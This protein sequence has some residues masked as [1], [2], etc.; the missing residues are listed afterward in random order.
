MSKPRPRSSSLPPSRAVALAAFRASLRGGLDLQSAL[1]EAIRR[2]ALDWR[3]AGLATE[4]VYGTLRLKG[5]LDALCDRFLSDPGRVPAKLRDILEI[6]AYEILFLDKVPDYASVDWAVSAARSDC[7]QGLAGLC[8]AVL[9]KIAKLG[10]VAHDPKFYQEGAKDEAAFL[11]RWHSCPEWMVRLWR[12]Q[13]PPDRVQA[14][15]ESQCRPPALGMR[16]N[17]LYGGH[18][19]LKADLLARPGLMLSEGNCLAFS[20]GT[21]PA[22]EI[23]P[24]LASGALSRQSAASQLAVHCLEPAQWPGPIWDACA[25]R[26]GKSLLLAEAGHAP[27]LASDLHMGRISGLAAECRRLGLSPIPAVLALADQPPLDHWQGTILIDAPCSGLGVLSRR[28]DSKW[29]R[30]PKDCKDLAVLQRRILDVCWSLLRPGGAIAYLTCTMNRDEN[31]KVVAGLLTSHKDA[32]LQ[33]ERPVD[34]ASPLG[35]FFYAALIRKK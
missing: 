13:M 20:P 34:P 17:P 14:A 12:A 18:E 27:A 30:A 19:N 3:D 22:S 15:L 7:G 11:A 9:R 5:R 24:L 4:L 21:I 10:D 1:D 25:G 32:R 2:G 23:S 6:A 35:E 16:L 26:G 8:N 29:K 28:P 33:I 31:E